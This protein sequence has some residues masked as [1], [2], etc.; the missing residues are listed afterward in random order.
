MMKTASILAVIATKTVILAQNST[1][2]PL[3]PEL[4]KMSHIFRMMDSQLGTDAARKTQYSTKDVGKMLQNYG[5]HCFPKNTREV[6][7]AGAAVDDYDQLCLNLARCHKC[8]EFDHMNFIDNSWDSDIGK[9]RF[10]SVGDGSIDCESGNTDPHKIDLCKCDAQFA[11]AMGGLWDDASYNFGHWGGKNNNLNTLDF[12]ATCVASGAG[13][14][15]DNCCGAYPN[16]QP[17]DSD[18]KD[19]CTD[20]NMVETK[21]YSLVS[22]ECCMDGSVASLGVGCP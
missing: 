2:A 22:S 10:T 9:Y 20:E 7:G 21:L 19:C 14:R 13:I 6:G 4:R 18:N 16:R 11:I 15:P 8:I 5:C 3:E 12:D 1:E 17:Y